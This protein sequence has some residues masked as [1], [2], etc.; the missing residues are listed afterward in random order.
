M[1]A[2]IMM[3]KNFKNGTYHPIWYVESPLPS[4]DESS[5]LKRF[6]SRMHHTSGFPTREEAL[7]SIETQ[8]IPRLDGYVITKDLDGDIEWDGEGIPA[9]IQFKLA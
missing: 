1:E 8:L 5:K 3:I 7:D 2:L 4:S 9:D 6:K